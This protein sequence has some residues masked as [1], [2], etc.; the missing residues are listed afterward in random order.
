[1]TS[2]LD[3]EMRTTTRLQTAA[4]E[5]AANAIFITNKTGVIVWANPA[6]E[7]LTGHPVEDVL[8][9]NPRIL[10][11]GEQDEDFYRDLWR[12]LLKGEVW[13]GRVTN[14]HKSGGLY[15]A[16][17]TITPILDGDGVVTHFVAIHED[18]TARLASEE[19]IA[20]MALHDFLT[21]LPNRYAL[22]SRLDIELI[23]TRRLGTR[24]ALLLIDFD[25]FKE[26]NDTFGHSAG[27]ELLV[28]VGQRLTRTLRDVDMICRLGGDEF[29]VVQPDI[30]SRRNAANL[31]ERLLRAFVETFDV[32]SQ[33]ISINAS[34]GVSVS[35]RDSTSKSEFVREADLA[36][37]RAKSEGRNT[38]RF[39]NSEMDREIKRRV[40]LAQDLHRAIQN[41][42]LFLEY[43][44]QVDLG[45]RRIVGIEA[46]LR[47]RH[48]EL[49]I[50]TPS[51]LA[52]IAESSGLTEEVGEWVLQAACRE[53]KTWQ[54][55]NLPA[56]PVAV[57]ISAVQ[58]RDPR[59]VSK[60]SRILA[61]TELEPRYLE[62]E[63]TERVLM[64]GKGNVE[65]TLEALDDLGVRI[66]L[67]N[68]GTGYASLDYLR[69]LPL[70]KIK[71]DR[72]FI[73]D[74]E[75]NLKNAAIVGAVIDLAAKLDLQVIAEGVGPA[76]LVQSLIDEGCNEIQGFNFSR[77]VSAEELVPLLTI[78]S[79][80]IQAYPRQEGGGL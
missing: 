38:Y 52:P 13:Q 78:G 8:G 41:D 61:K 24:V 72:S 56:L 9:L 76:G 46:L 3:R 75:T 69:R 26:V 62:L 54:S 77:P 23:R 44:P 30:A 40:K 5:S 68:F 34:I 74:M 50:V 35:S 25:N 70:S 39:F 53:A 48:P 16:E 33:E 2:E 32:G 51:E 28:A 12:T 11:S 80:H 47:W 27:D 17:Q 43:Q 42:E 7:V 63:L 20:H 58:L 4:I 65:R 37:Y 49:D 45:N 19:R 55:R 60:V 79:D 57:N 15:T 29:A 66:S 1:M 67:D 18:I 59:F 6:F 36:L 21:D 10:K 31:A 64:E 73:H 22:D 14:R 71:I